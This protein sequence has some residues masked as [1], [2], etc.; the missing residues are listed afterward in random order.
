MLSQTECYDFKCEINKKSMELLISKNDLQLL[1]NN[2]KATAIHNNEIKV[3]AFFN[4]VR[5]KHI[6][7]LNSSCDCVHLSSHITS[8]SSSAQ[9]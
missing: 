1:C 6:N 9:N 4:V 3:N 2:K 7:I 5:E 8:H